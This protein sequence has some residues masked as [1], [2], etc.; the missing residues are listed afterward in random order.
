MAFEED[1]STFF[2]TDGFGV[3]FVYTPKIGGPVTGIGIFDAAHFA[4][5]GGEVSVEGNQPQIQYE[6]ST[7]SDPPVYGDKIA[8]NGKDYTIVGVHPDGTG[9]TTLILELDT[10]GTC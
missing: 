1:F 8:V 9:T 4:V 2:N 6:T 5:A 3:E 10:D 7:I